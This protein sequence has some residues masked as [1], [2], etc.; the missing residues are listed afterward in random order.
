M[1]VTPNS[2]NFDYDVR[3]LLGYMPPGYVVAGAG[4][5]EY[6]GFYLEGGE[7]NGKPWYEI[8][9][10]GKWINY[11]DQNKWIISNQVPQ[12][13]G[14]TYVLYESADDDNNKPPSTGWTVVS[15]TA[16]VPTVTHS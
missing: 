16:P 15:G 7:L 4:S 9:T 2:R 12:N 6:D 11:S 8:T 14:P 5:S 13:G 10:G 3:S 1:K